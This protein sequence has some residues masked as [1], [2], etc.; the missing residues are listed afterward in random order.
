[1]SQPYSG[2]GYG[3]PPAAYND[4]AAAAPS[5]ASQAMYYQQ[6][7]QRQMPAPG[8]LPKLPPGVSAQNGLLYYDGRPYADVNYQSPMGPNPYQQVAYRQAMQ[9]G[10]GSTP[11]S[12][13]ATDGGQYD[14]GNGYGGYGYSGGGPYGGP[15]NRY[16]PMGEGDGYGAGGE[17]NDGGYGHH[18]LLW[19]WLHR[20]PFPGKMGYVWSGGFD[21][22]G[23]NRDNGTNV[24][25]VENT[26]SL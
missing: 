16:G 22:L 23:M 17:C 24:V 9:S 12:C 15:M 4:L 6:A 14:P 8:R 11:M 3:A 18:G 2:Y 25:L 5:D 13:T 21:V 7:M 26:N 20:G 10:M 1:N 19:S